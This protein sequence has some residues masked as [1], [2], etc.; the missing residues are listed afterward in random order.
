MNGLHL[1][2]L[3]R[4]KN[5]ARNLRRIPSIH[6]CGEWLPT[7]GFV[8]DALVQFFPEEFGGI[9]R[10]C[11]DNI[12]SYSELSRQTKDKGGM[13]MNA[14]LYD[15]KQCPSLNVTGN[16]VKRTG[17]VFDDKLLVRY[18][19]GLIHIR[20]LPDRQT[21]VNSRL[22]GQWLADL[23]FV[24]EAVVTVASEP[25]LITC[26]LH[27]DG[28]ERAR[29]AELVKYVR[30]NDMSL[31][32]VHKMQGMGTRAVIPEIDIPHSRLVK[33]GFAPDEMVLA[34]YEYGRIQLQKLDFASLGFSS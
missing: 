28:M 17:L 27:E 4:G 7:V 19:F 5:E 3:T 12:A 21:V 9:F 25:G 13:L 2:N 22:S 1:I 18:E 8:T 20:K 15:R 30:A 11:D 29:T 26:Q 6:I 23:G 34:S 31:L 32:Q 24:H 33:A 14:R 16:F 10:L